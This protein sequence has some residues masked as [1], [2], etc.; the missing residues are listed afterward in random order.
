MVVELTR[1]KRTDHEVWPL[2]GLVDR[3][4]LVDASGDRLKVGDVEDPGV[5]AAIPTNGVDGVE[6]IP[7]AGDQFPDLHAYLK[8]A[9]LGV[10]DQFLGPAD[11]AFA[12]GRVL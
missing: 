8:I 2:E 9:A 5:L 12:I 6:V 4:G 1:H 3:W 11:V 7:V 10:R